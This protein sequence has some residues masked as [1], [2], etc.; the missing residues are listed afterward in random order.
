MKLTDFPRVVER[1]AYAQSIQR[2]VAGLRDQPAVA[3]VYQV[4]GIRSPGISD[5][6]LLVV[7]HDDEPRTL[8]PLAGLEPADRYLF[9]HSQFGLTRRDW[10]V[11]VRFGFFHDY[12]LLHGEPVAAAVPPLAPEEAAVVNRQTGLEYLLKMY[13]NMTVERA[14]GIVRVRNLLLL[15]RALRYDLEYVGETDGPVARLVT[16]VIGWRERWFQAPPSRPE[17]VAW[18]QALYGELQALLARV[19]EQGPLYVPDWADLRIAG[20]MGLANAPALGCTR[21]GISLPAALGAL[22]RRYFNLQHRFNDFRFAVPLT[23]SGP[24]ILSER[25]ARVAGMLE[26]NRLR[27]PHFI[28]VSSALNIFRRRAPDIFRRQAPDIVR[29]KGPG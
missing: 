26:Y 29:R 25:H 1:E 14:Y 10:P 21:R 9:P 7:F 8:D 20:N 2:V 18:F 6:D 17:L 27:L 5:V 16:Q 11:A 13:I 23:N 24:E 19:L 12:H 28:P 4:G 22:G 3:A 15:G